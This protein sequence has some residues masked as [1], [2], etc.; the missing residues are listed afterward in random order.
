M[1]LLVVVASDRPAAAKPFL[2][3][4]DRGEL[5]AKRALPG[6]SLSGPFRNLDD[7]FT[8]P[9]PSVQHPDGASSAPVTDRLG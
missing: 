4:G 3:V 7:V 6:V 8:P 1:R 9:A 5:L 2:S